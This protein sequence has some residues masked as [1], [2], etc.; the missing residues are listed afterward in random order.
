[1]GFD[2]GSPKIILGMGVTD[3]G[4]D[5]LESRELPQENGKAI[6]SGHEQEQIP[7]NREDV[8]SRGA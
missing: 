5:V 1:V 8:A 3:P 4:R 2:F 7:E 6:D